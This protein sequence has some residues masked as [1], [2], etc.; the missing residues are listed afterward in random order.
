[1]TD[2]EI[3][4]L[5]AKIADKLRTPP[6]EEQQSFGDGV[7]I[8]QME[9]A[10]MEV[11]AANGGSSWINKWCRKYARI[12]YDIRLAHGYKPGIVAEYLREAKEDE[13]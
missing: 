11:A 9:C 5:A 7:R 8:N 13:Q 2:E 12:I 3:D 10:I 4:K 1:M 6:T